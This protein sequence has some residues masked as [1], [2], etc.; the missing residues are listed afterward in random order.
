MEDFLQGY[1]TIQQFRPHVKSV[2]TPSG[3]VEIWKSPHPGR[4]PDQQDR[5]MLNELT[6]SGLFSY[7]KINDAAD[8]DFRD[9]LPCVIHKAEYPYSW[10]IVDT[11]PEKIANVELAPIALV[12]DWVTAQ[13]DR[14]LGSKENAR[15][16][17]IEDGRYRFGLFDNGNSLLMEHGQARPEE[18]TEPQYT[19]QLL[20]SRLV[21]NREALE[22]AIKEVSSWPIDKIIYEQFCKYLKACKRTEESFQFIVNYQNQVVNFI[23]FRLSIVPSKLLDTWYDGIHHPVILSDS[24]PQAALVQ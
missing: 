7:G 8:F 23:R 17:K 18:N 6:V 15:L 5:E 21:T 14:G 4:S 11:Q 20:L 10:D 9:S 22:Q 16:Q 24:M 1:K 19:S 13:Q 2:R 12:V 3:S